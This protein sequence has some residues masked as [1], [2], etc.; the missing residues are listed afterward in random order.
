[1]ELLTV[2]GTKGILRK[3]LYWCASPAFKREDC[4][5]KAQA[6]HFTHGESH[7]F[8]LNMPSLAVSIW[9]EDQEEDPHK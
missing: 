5:T 1:M 3:Q 7:K 6:D 8:P 2:F 4:P 9:K